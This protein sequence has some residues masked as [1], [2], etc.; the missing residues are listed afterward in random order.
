M[1]VYATLHDGS[2]GAD[3]RPRRDFSDQS[4]AADWFTR[5]LHGFT[6][7][8]DPNPYARLDLYDG[9]VLGMRITTL[10][11]IAN[12]DHTYR[13]VDRRRGDRIQRGYLASGINLREAES[14]YL[15]AQ[16]R[17]ALLLED[18]GVADIPSAYRATILLGIRYM[19]GTH[20][21]ATRM[22]LQHHESREFGARLFQEHTGGGG[23]RRPSTGTLYGVEN[24]LHTY[25]LCFAPQPLHCN[26]SQL[27]YGA[28]HH[29]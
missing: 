9:P 18:F 16:L 8:P 22:W 29:E 17:A 3:L 5:Y 19:A 1:T 12:P 26:G 10:S 7:D 13:I 14:G 21:L 6:D 4:A 2:P 28:R 25:A 20:P 23:F 11:G 24:Q 15:A 27:C